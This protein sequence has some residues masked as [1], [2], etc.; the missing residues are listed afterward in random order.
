MNYLVSGHASAQDFEATAKRVGI[1][2]AIVCAAEKLPSVLA[3]VSF[4]PSGRVFAVEELAKPM[5]AGA[6]PPPVL[7]DADNLLWRIGFSSGTTGGPK[8]IGWT[9]KVSLLNSGQLQAM[10]PAGPGERM[11]IAMGSETL[12]ASY[13][14]LGMLHS[15]GC[16]IFPQSKP[17]AIMS[18]ISRHQPSSVLTS[19]YAASVLAEIATRTMPG[20]HR[21]T[22]PSLKMIAVGGGKMAVEQQ[23]VLRER[24]AP[25]LIDCYG[26]S[27]AC[28]LARG[29]SE[30]K[31]KAPQYVGRLTP[32]AEGEAV[33][34]NDKPLPPGTVGR[35][36]FRNMAMA[37]G[38]L[39]DEAA[40]AKYFKNGWFYPGDLGMVTIQGLLALGGAR[41]ISSTSVG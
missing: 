5:P 14:W 11:L 34:E 6:Q 4:L 8:A 15:G 24:F 26:S 25:E 23:R 21:V 3:S 36:R 17:D 16:S 37:D 9:H 18:A 35:L 39:G 20:E 38:Y 30:L 29:P 32:W 33:D 28:F 10:Y 12:F 19:S 40:T 7:S 1:T 41:T 2:A 22:P 27:E 31:I 13:H